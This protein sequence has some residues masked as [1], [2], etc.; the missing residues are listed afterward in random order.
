MTQNQQYTY[1]RFIT[2][3]QSEREQTQIPDSRA[4]QHYVP[5]PIIYTL[6][7]RSAW[8]KIVNENS[9]AT[10]K[11]KKRKHNRNRNRNSNR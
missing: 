2:E 8:Q 9:N 6:E 7:F 1:P 3:E 10:Q 11:I 4:S 5:S